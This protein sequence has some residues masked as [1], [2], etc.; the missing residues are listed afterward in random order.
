MAAVGSC[1]FALTAWWIRS[2]VAGFICWSAEGVLRVTS[3]TER[4]GGR[5]SVRG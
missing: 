3:A 4:G 5:I 1:V 2:Q